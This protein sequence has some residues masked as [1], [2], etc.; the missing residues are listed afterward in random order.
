LQA[1]PGQSV[2]EVRLDDVAP[3]ER[4]LSHGIFNDDIERGPTA[5][6][7]VLKILRGFV[8]NDA[9]P[10]VEVVRFPTSAQYRYKLTHG[11]HRFYLSIAAGF[12]HVPAIDGFDW[13]TVRS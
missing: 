10:P 9:I 1:F 3:V 13:D 11:V 7:R 6:D 8:A 2:Y 5:K 4:K 12:T